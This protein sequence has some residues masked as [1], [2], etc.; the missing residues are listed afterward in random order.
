MNRLYEFFVG[1]T[2][3]PMNA[4]NADTVTLANGGTH[5]TGTFLS[6]WVAGNP[7]PSHPMVHHPAPDVDADG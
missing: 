3:A 5:G 1:I 7:H 6:D 2:S 4:L